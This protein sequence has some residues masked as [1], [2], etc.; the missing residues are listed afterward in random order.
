MNGIA[1]NYILLITFIISLNYKKYIFGLL[2]EESSFIVYIAMQ[3][4][5]LIY[6]KFTLIR[7]CYVTAT[8]Q[9]K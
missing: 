7:D 3:S 2:L 9:C 1:T 4:V 5:D 6:L 8:K